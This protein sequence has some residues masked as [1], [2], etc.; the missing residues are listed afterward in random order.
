MSGFLNM[1]AQDNVRVF[2]NLS[3]FAKPR[4]I[5]YDGKT[6]EGVPCMI[7]GLHESKRSTTAS[8]HSMGMYKVTQILHCT[9]ESLGGVQPEVGTRLKISDEDDPTFFWEYYVASSNCEEGM[10]RVELEGIYE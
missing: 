10:L 8:D 5:V 2:L 9:K 4:T 1:V 3:E 7:N 6:Y